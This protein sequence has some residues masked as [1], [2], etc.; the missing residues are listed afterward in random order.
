MLANSNIYSA[1]YMAAT[2]HLGMKTWSRQS[3]EVQTEDQNQ[4]QKGK[5]SDFKRGM[6][7]AVRW[8]IYNNINNICC[9]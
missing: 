3:A 7:F 9:I 6:V 1:N 8:A 5:L 2:Q 4:N